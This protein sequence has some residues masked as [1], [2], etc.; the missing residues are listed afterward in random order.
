MFALSTGNIEQHIGVCTKVIS[1]W[2]MTV[3]NIAKAHM[4]LGTLQGSVALL[5]GIS[6][7]STLYAGNWARVSSPSRKKILNFP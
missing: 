2:V 4:F 5:G 7:M 6:L 1:S 3:L